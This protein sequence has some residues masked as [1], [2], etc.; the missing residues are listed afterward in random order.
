MQPVIIEDR[1]T[2]G[3]NTSI[4]NIIASNAGLTRYNRA[5]FNA[6]GAVLFI[7]SA[8]G[9]LISLSH[10][11]KEVV[12]NA[13]PRVGADM[14]YPN[15]CINEDWYV[16]E[17]EMLNLAVV[18]PTGGA[19]ILSYRIVLHPWEEALPPDSLVMQAGPVTIVNNTFGLDILNGL[20]YS[21]PPQPCILDVYM[22]AS[23]AGLQREIFVDTESISPV[24]YIPPLNRIP[25]KPFDV[26]VGGIEAPQDKQIAI[27]ITNVS[28]GPLSVFWRTVMQELS[29]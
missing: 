23:A 11:S 3:A 21:R 9:L 7:Q 4:P 28:G 24:T 25:Q 1:I 18:N 12:F 19:I 22:T 16:E 29:R 2:V 13:S 14:Q 27:P 15:D 6:K 5:P 17:G 10:G 20:K 8:T 26:V